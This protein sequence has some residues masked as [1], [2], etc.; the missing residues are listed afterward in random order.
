MLTG[1]D[2]TK[3]R[4]GHRAASPASRPRPT[5][6]AASAA[7]SG[8]WIRAAAAGLG[9]RRGAPQPFMYGQGTAPPYRDSDTRTRQADPRGVKG[10]CI[11]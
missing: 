2:K 5:Q 3:R 10:T 4:A 11:P 6:A 1:R 9:D 8:A 7:A